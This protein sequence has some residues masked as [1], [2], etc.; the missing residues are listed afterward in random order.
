M[1]GEKKGINIDTVTEVK[2]RK[3]FKI[4]VMGDNVL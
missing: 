4:E 1:W 3:S 2:E